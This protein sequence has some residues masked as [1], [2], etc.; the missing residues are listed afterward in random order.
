[1]S[2]PDPRLGELEGVA[3]RFG[4]VA[5]YDA[6]V[7]LVMEFGGRRLSVPVKMRPSS[8]FW[9]KLG[10]IAAKALAKLFGGEDITVPTGSKA[11][12]KQR[13]RQVRNY[14]LAQRDP[15]KVSKNDLAEKFKVH[16]RTV[17]RV[18]V[19]L[20]QPVAETAQTDL[21]EKPSKSV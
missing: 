20:G 7:R 16:R 2:A 14:L 12:E 3:R 9:S 8:P 11:S 10:P 13:R 6:A 17:Q 5:G 4:R 1:M 19:A 15:S 18:R 21:F